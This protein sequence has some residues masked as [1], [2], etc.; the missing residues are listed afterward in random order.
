MTILGVFVRINA[1]Y[2][3]TGDFEQILPSYELNS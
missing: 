2:V 3:I 1:E